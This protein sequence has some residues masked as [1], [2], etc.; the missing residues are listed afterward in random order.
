MSFFKS[1]RKRMS[2]E[3][4]RLIDRLPWRGKEPIRPK[5]VTASPRRYEGKQN[6]LTDPGN[7]IT[8]FTP[9]DKH[10]RVMQYDSGYYHPNSMNPAAVASKHWDG[11]SAKAESVGHTAFRPQSTEP[12]A[13]CVDVLSWWEPRGTRAPNVTLHEIYY[14]A[15]YSIRFE[16]GNSRD[17]FGA[18]GSAHGYIVGPD[19]AVV[20]HMDVNHNRQTSLR[21]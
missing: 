18:P 7:L 6:V 19:G 21:Y 17:H 3:L 1:L 13:Y 5:P 20:T 10:K 11:I 16:I 9:D 14:D 8:W 4:Q 12:V 2:D 15:G